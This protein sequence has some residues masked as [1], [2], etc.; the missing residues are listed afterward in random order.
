MNRSKESPTQAATADSAPSRS[1]EE[2][3]KAELPVGIVALPAQAQADLAATV[4]RA[5]RTQAEELKEAAYSMLDLIPGFLRG[6]VK[7]AAGI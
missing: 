3:V 4:A 1:L 2:L 7:K 6:A 5:K